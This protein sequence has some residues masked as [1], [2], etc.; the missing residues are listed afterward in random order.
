MGSVMSTADHRLGEAPRP[1]LSIQSTNC[2]KGAIDR[3]GEYNI[4]TGSDFIA[5]YTT[6]QEYKYADALSEYD[7]DWVKL[8]AQGKSARRTRNIACAD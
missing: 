6:R 8:L 3:T 7:Q 2:P 4:N 1:F 5:Q